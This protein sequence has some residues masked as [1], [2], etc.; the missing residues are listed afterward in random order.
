MTS[1]CDKRRRHC[2]RTHIR[3]EILSH[4]NFVTFGRFVRSCGCLGI[5][6]S[7]WKT[8]NTKVANGKLNEN[9]CDVKL[10]LIWYELSR[11]RGNTL[12]VEKSRRL[13]KMPLH[14]DVVLQNDNEK[15]EIE[16]KNGKKR[17]YY[18]ILLLYFRRFV[19]VIASVQSLG[20]ADPRIYATTLH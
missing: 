19:Y 14:P 13:E 8:N 6:A 1:V 17:N 15:H 5:S 7:K 12:N 2:R 3:T 9:E 20:A 10:T 11:V 16:R 18:Y 4:E